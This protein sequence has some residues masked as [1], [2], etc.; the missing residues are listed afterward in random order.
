MSNAVGGESKSVL[1]FRLRIGRTVIL[2][3]RGIWLG[4]TVDPTSNLDERHEEVVA[5]TVVS[6]VERVP[7]LSD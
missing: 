1:R 6:R 3:A 5:G 2:E 7:E 4:C